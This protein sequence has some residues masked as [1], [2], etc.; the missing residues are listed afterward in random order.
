MLK[1]RESLVVEALSVLIYGV[2][3]LLGEGRIVAAVAEH[4][5]DVTFFV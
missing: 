5:L 1:G 3:G 4:L 2:M